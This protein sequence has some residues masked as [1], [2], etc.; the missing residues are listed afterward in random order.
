MMLGIGVDLIEIDR[1]QKLLDQY[2]DH[3]LQR[4]LVPA[5][6]TYCQLH[7]RPAP[8]VAAR[9]A[10]KEAIAKAFGTGIGERLGWHDIEIVRKDTGEPEVI[11]H[12]AARKLAEQ[13]GGTRVRISLSHTADH[14]VAVAILE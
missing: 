8:H 2:G 10:A 11:L 1:I 6:I 12:D 14:A 13:R 7:R 3:F 9:F 5:E 4:I